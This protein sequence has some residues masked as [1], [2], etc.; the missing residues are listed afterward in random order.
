MERC[1]V[2]VGNVGARRKRGERWPALQGATWG[3][4]YAAVAIGRSV[5]KD[6]SHVCWFAGLMRHDAMRCDA[7]SIE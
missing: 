2:V 4:R 7:T 5:G 6:S 1:G 3:R